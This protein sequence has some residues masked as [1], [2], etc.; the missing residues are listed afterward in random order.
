MLALLV[1]ASSAHAGKK[2]VVVLDFDGPKGDQFQEQVEAVLKKAATLVAADKW[3][4]AADELGVKKM[5]AKGVAKVAAKLRI[6]GVVVGSVDRRGSRYFV[7]VRLREGKSGEFVSEVELVVRSGKLSSSD[8]AEVK[9]QIAGGIAKLSAPGSADDDDEDA[10]DDRPARGKD[11]DKGKHRDDDEDAEAADDRGKD[12]GKHRDDD[13]DDDR[14]KGKDRDDEDRVASRDDDKDRDDREDD[15]DLHGSASLA[16]DPRHRPLEALAGLSFTARR[17]SFRTEPTLTNKPQ[18]YKGAPVAGAYVDATLYPLA[19]NRKNKSILRDV[20]VQL[21]LDRVI[22][23][24]SKLAYKDGAGANQT[25]TLGTTEQHLAVG[26]A[27]RYALGKGETGPVLIGSV[28]YNRL[29]FVIDKGAVPAGA[30]TPDIPNTDYT[31]VDPG[32]A[33]QYPASPKLRVGGG[34]RVLVITDTGEMQNVDQ[35]G[36]A[37]V[38][39]FD[40]DLGA[41]Y[42]LT[43]NW[44]VHAGLALH[45]IGFTF[46]GNGALTNNRDGDATTV[47]V[48]NARDNYFGGAITAGYAY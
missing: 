15:G 11:K 39:G 35:Y 34:A 42:T 20:G 5:T 27:F 3:S 4:D 43:R 38:I 8:Q 9:D 16:S 22:K 26:L 12:K 23:I 48:H 24:E 32:V 14:D 7:H 18:G 19:F 44:F 31:Y 6:D 46:K 29:K 17:L 21:M 13:E 37:T 45:T 41:D 40:V 25:A 47:D 33:I 2:R 36:A 28:R 10:D 1:A 30:P